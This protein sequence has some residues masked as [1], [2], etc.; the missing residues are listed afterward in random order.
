MRQVTGSSPHA[1]GTRLDGAAGDGDA[2]IIPACAGNT[3]AT[4]SQRPTRR[5]HPRMRGEHDACPGMSDLDWGSSPHARGTRRLS[6]WRPGRVGIIPACAGNTGGRDDGQGAGWDHPRMR[7]EHGQ[8]QDGRG[9]RPGSS[10]HARGT[11]SDAQSRCGSDR[12]IPACAGNTLS[13]LMCGVSFGDHPRMRGEHARMRKAS[14]TI[15]GSSPHAR[16]TR[17]RW[18]A[19]RTV[20]GIIPACAGN[21][22]FLVVPARKRRDHPRMRGEH[23]RVAGLVPCLAGSSP[24]ARGTHYE[25]CRFPPIIISSFIFFIYFPFSRGKH[26]IS[27]TVVVRTRIASTDRI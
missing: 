9:A 7:G 4:R 20:T 13:P 3:K 26:G 23:V 5:D 19:T 11:L 24:H 6:V 16:G 25:K 22:H 2:G 8:A 1:R 17:T 21:T 10:P 12:I 27:I 14:R 18:S 15:R